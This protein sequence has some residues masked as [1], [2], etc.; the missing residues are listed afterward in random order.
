M[1]KFIA[2]WISVLVAALCAAVIT[3]WISERRHSRL[4]RRMNAKKWLR[5]AV[6]SLCALSIPLL[7]TK[8]REEDWNRLEQKA[9]YVNR[10]CSVSAYLELMADI[11]IYADQKKGHPLTI[12]NEC[13]S[14]MLEA[15]TVLAAEKFDQEKWRIFLQGANYQLE[16]L[17]EGYLKHA[18][19][20]E[21]S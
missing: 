12:I 1:E 15:N 6:Q 7:D 13:I 16:L 5:D 3:F 11:S 10:Y 4:I 19:A 14:W 8:I 18:T 9:R 17:K 2:T 20:A 21:E